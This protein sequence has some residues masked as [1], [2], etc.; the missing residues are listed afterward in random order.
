MDTVR[1]TFLGGKSGG[2][3]SLWEVAVLGEKGAPQPA[4]AAKNL[5]ADASTSGG[6][7]N[8]KAAQ[9][10]GGDADKF[11][12]TPEEV[13]NVALFLC[14]PLASYVSGQTIEVNGAWRG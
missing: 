13:A 8:G 4:V 10:K 6:K 14:S 11:L 7:K 3:G 2:W 5:S 12:P 9:Q 1:V